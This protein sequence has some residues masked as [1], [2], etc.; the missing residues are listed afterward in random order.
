M[1]LADDMDLYDPSEFMEFRLI[2][3]PSKS[4]YFWKQKNKELISLTDMT[5]LHII[6]ILNRF[7][8]KLSDET[9]ILFQNELRRRKLLNN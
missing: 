1:S 4:D 8:D 2:F 3:D 5:N 7:E 6:R 9:I